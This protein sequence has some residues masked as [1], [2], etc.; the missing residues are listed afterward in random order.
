MLSSM[1]NPLKVALM[2]I[3]PHNR[4]I[5]EFF[6]AGAGKKLFAPVAVEQAEALIIDFDHPGGRQEWQAQDAGVFKPAIVISVKE[7]VEDNIV[8]VPKPLTSQALAGA[9]ERVRDLMPAPTYHAQPAPTSASDDN[10]DSL[11]TLLDKQARDVRPFGMPD[12]PRFKTPP[13][14][15]VSPNRSRSET[16]VHTEASFT[17]AERAG[18]DQVHAVAAHDEFAESSEQDQHF[19]RT[20]DVYIPPPIEEADMPAGESKF[21]FDNNSDDPLRQELRWDRLCGRE[22]TITRD[23]WRESEALYSPADYLLHKL[24][25]GLELSHKFKQHVQLEIGD[26]DAPDGEYMLL[27]PDV[28]L[29]YSS[30]PLMSDAF[31]DLCASP[32]EVDTVQLHLPSSAELVTL[33]DNI[34][35]DSEH[36]YD[37]E[38]LI[39]TMSLLT[40][41][42]R[43]NQH[44]VSLDQPLR[45]KSWPNLTRLE[46][47]PHV[48]QIAAAWQQRAGNVFDVAEWFDIPQRYVIAFYNASHTLSLFTIEQA[49]SQSE[50][51]P[52][53]RKNRGLFSRL[54]KR[55]LGGG[56]K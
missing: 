40:S 21:S 51:T 12:Q 53:P 13:V 28:N 22:A 42:G 44:A 39:W 52:A 3:S 14:A 4:A 38:A 47:F 32:L 37:M 27:M 26:S 25:D 54:L 49:S 23:N 46:H 19:L 1:N 36:T 45:L 9:A 7:T 29:I 5:L 15:P 10:M 50:E 56:A 11:R 6:F 8:W 48:M 20:E 55:L 24:I 33:Q 18:D 31:A 43:L 35:R 34:Q 30:V 16:L 2:S 41:R 17:A